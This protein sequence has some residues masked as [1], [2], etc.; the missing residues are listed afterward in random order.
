MSNA[1]K[2]AAKG[3]AYASAAREKEERGRLV[4]A[5]SLYLKAASAFLEASKVT[6]NIN[7]KNLR[8]QLAETFYGK[9]MGIIASRVAKT[10]R[11][12][13][14]GSGGSGSD[15]DTI[16]IVPIEKPNINFSYVGG[17]DDVKNE[18][19]KV[20]VYPFQHPEIYEH[21][22]K[23]IGEGILMYGPPGCGKT[24]IAKAAAGECGASFIT[25][26]VGEILS[27]WLGESEK[28]VKAAFEAAKKHQPSILFFDEI[29]AIGGKRD[30]S[31]DASKRVVN[32]LLVELDGV[33]TTRDK[34]L[35]L[36]AT[37]APWDVDPALR[38]PGRFSKLLFLPP[39]DLDSRRQIFKLGTKDRPL[40]SDV[41]FDE[42]ANKTDGYSSADIIQICDEAADVPLEEALAGKTPR[43]IN[44]SD[45]LIVIKKRKSS[46][47]PWFKLAYNQ[48]TES[49]EEE[50]FSELLKLIDNFI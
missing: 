50:E 30:E 22:R 33:T 48:I 15:E 4:D 35:V 37:N 24:F 45:F 39:P 26:K 25:L 12:S 6:T 21:Y 42:L 9:A 16:K 31:S 23:K 17:L 11:V 10:G 34:R 32:A 41:N 7:E 29:D 27:K 19:R 36:A 1:H 2:Y 5:K 3:K 20:I 49:G 18:I 47:I 44:H 38:R 43:K 28:N 13:G 40:E 8:Q 14:S 46:I